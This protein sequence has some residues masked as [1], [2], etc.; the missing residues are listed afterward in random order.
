MNT[1]FEFD[2]S[3]AKKLLAEIASALAHDVR[4]PV[5][6]TGQF[7]ELMELEGGTGGQ[8]SHLGI[9]KDSVGIV[10]D[11]LDNVINFIRLGRG[12]SPSEDVD[13][14]QLARTAFDRARLALEAETISFDFEGE[15]YGVGHDVRLM[16][17][18]LHLFEN[19]IIHG[20]ASQ[21]AVQSARV[22]D[23]VELYISDNGPGIPA[24]FGDTA[25][26]LFIKTK[27]DDPNQGQ[28]VGLSMARRIA[29]LHGG[30]L[31]IDTSRKAALPGLSI[32]LSLP[33]D[34]QIPFEAD[35]T[36]EEEVY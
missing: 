13:F 10:S 5:R 3:D 14:E 33:L 28:G 1:S 21:I 29:E 19:S 2:Q 6:H 20:G 32:L 25:F 24:D 18:F 16:E 27:T 34:P 26:T 12:L 31:T 8:D 11:M 36:E 17:L 4:T 15:K 23:H 30:T 22:G 9:V 35:A 7:L